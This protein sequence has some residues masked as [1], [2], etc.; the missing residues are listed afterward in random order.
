MESTIEALDTLTGTSI[1][2]LPTSAATGLGRDGVL[3]YISSLRQTFRT[4]LI[5][6]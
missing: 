6:K 5:F 3:K 1:P 4:P 2:Y